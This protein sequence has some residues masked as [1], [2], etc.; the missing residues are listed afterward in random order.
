MA[1]ASTSTTLQRISDILRDYYL[2]PAVQALNCPSVWKAWWDVCAKWEGH[3]AAQIEEE[4]ADGLYDP[5]LQQIATMVLEEYEERMLVSPLLD[6]SY[7][8][9]YPVP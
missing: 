8:V 3:Y 5:L 1:G 4:M 7:M 9:P 2:A 6:K